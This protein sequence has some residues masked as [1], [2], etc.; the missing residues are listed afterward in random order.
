MGNG[1]YSDTYSRMEARMENVEQEITSIRQWM[2]EIKGALDEMKASRREEAENRS[3]HEN[4]THGPS[5]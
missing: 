2:K 4:Q 5:G 1:E 3:V